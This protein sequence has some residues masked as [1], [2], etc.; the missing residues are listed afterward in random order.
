MTLHYTPNYLF[1][2]QLNGGL[3]KEQISAHQDKL[4][5]AFAK[6][7][8]EKAAGTLG[9][10]KLPYATDQLAEIQAMADGI[11]AKFASVV[12]IGIGGPDL[13]TR[14]VHRA[15][16]HQYFNQSEQVRH[17]RPQLFFVGDTTD[18]I[19][20]HE[21]LDVVD[22]HK[23]AVVM[24]SKSGNTLE[25]MASFIV[26][27]D[28]LIQVVGADQARQ[29][30][31]TITDPEKGTL[32]E[33]TNAEGYAN[34]CVPTDVGGRFAV[35]S[36]V[37]LFPLA[38]VGVDIAALLHG[39]S[40]MDKADTGSESSAPAQFAFHQFLA[41][42]VQKRPITV[43]FPYSYAMR[44]IGLWFRQLWAE[45]LGKKMSLDGEVVHT[46]PTPIAAVG[47][48]DQHSQVQLYMEGPQDKIMTFVRVTET[49][50][51]ITL[52]EAFPEKEGVAYM[53]GLSMQHILLAEESATAKALAQEGR[54]STELT[55]DS[56]DA[57]NIGQLLYF[58]ELATAY[59]GY[60]WN[61]D[62]YDQPGVEL[63]KT[64]MYQ[65][66]GRSGF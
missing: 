12:V 25:Q 60:L 6:V 13:G 18:P 59:A 10:A 1:E 17:G 55:L 44:E 61:V 28:H 40:D 22:L 19:V 27:R 3:T 42:T 4:D 7:Q 62:A 47:P 31:F 32:R 24:V 11:A 29:Q 48:T 30:I 51:D 53:K 43:M 23:T 56:L 5:A 49:K 57:Y 14:A 58:F 9:F 41:Y 66:L 38:I 33:I 21:L 34:L 39:A 35:L 16:N 65:A 2:D 37:G 50:R 45:S 26:L 64:L 8:Q 36:P 54:P 15:L 52:P 46:G 20:L 63:G